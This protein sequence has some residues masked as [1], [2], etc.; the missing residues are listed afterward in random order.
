[1]LEAISVLQIQNYYKE[2]NFL[3]NTVA[4]FRFLCPASCL[5]PNLKPYSQY[6]SEN[7]ISPYPAA[8]SNWK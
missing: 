5:L 8:P 3:M 7:C 1:M 6:K 2:V 4:A